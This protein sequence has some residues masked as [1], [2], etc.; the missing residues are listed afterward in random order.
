MTRIEDLVPLRDEMTVWRRRL[1]QNPETA[2]EEFATA[3]LVVEQL[4][5]FGLEVHA[6]LA[7][8][9]VVGVLRAGGAA[10]AIGLRADMDALP[11]AEAN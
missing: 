9:G 8:T 7:G 5:S 11:I 1:H 10:T 2:F 4:T 3:Q 6:G